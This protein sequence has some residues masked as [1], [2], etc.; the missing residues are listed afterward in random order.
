MQT[1]ME[2]GNRERAALY[3]SAEW[4]RR[5][6]AFLKRLNRAGYAGGKLA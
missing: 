2:R 1:D 5:R 6:A 4:K 3:A